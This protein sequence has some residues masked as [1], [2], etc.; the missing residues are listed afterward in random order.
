[1]NFLKFIYDEIYL[2]KRIYVH[3]FINRFDYTLSL[4]C[5]ISEYYIKQQQNYIYLICLLLHFN[6]LTIS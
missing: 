3:I 2:L 6:F 1:M 5:Y 4:V